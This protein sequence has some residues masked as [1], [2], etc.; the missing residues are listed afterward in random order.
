MALNDR[1]SRGGR[2]TGLALALIAMVIVM[3]SWPKTALG[4][5]FCFLT[6][7]TSSTNVP[8]SEGSRKPS[9]NATGTRI[10]FESGADL[11]G[12]NSERRP[13]IFLFDATSRTFT[14][15]TESPPGSA[16]RQGSFD[17]VI[18]ATGTRIVFRSN[19]DLTGGNPGN[20]GH[21]F[22]FDTTTGTT[23]Q[24]MA[25]G[26]FT[27]DA[28]GNRIAFVSNEDLTGDNAD[29]SQEIFLL[30]GIAGTLTQIT[31]SPNDAASGVFHPS[32]NATGTRIA[33]DS[34][35]DLTGDNPDRS[36]EI[37]LYD[38]TTGITTQ[39]TSSTN[40][41]L[42]SYGPSIN[43]TGTRIAFVSNA[44]LTGGNSDHNSEIF[45]FDTTTSALIQITNSV[46]SPLGRD[47]RSPSI[48]ATGTR[49]AF[50]FRADLTG[51]NPDG[52]EEIFLAGCVQSV[53]STP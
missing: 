38:T 33:F 20:T 6:Q 52:N 15:L 43:A 24:V 7:I 23:T 26:I 21:I 47:R 29:R 5:P 34:G 42:S 51:G 8:G 17:P 16:A 44:D 25:A 35:V 11:T 13:E 9:I 53:T 37:F 2:L 3:G 1:C 18:N 46:G 41:F 27:I 32:M 4:E 19:S 30:D 14:Q 48:N 28:T 45:L 12:G 40:S 10:A 49:I 36:R 39:I 50:E 22:L 31:D